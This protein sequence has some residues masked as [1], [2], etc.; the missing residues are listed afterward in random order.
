MAYEATPAELGL[1]LGL[2]PPGPSR[3]QL[4][5]EAPDP[6]S[7]LVRISTL[8]PLLITARSKSTVIDGDA[9]Q[10]LPLLT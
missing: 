5:D 8:S 1:E 9:I 10:E 6:L 7:I 4:N 2:I 3:V